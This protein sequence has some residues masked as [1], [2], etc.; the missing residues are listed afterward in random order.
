MKR[1]LVTFAVAFGSVS[2]AAC[3]TTSPTNTSP[4]ATGTVSGTFTLDA[5]ISLPRPIDGTV[6]LSRWH[7]TGSV[8]VAVGE[9]GKFT[10]HLPPGM[11]VVSGR[12][13]KFNVNNREPPCGSTKP[14]TVVANS[15]TSV[16]LQCVGK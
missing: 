11:W 14:I 3:G 6:S 15:T 7:G 13:P 12:S 1:M 2:L 5:G 10:V 16:Q 4:P 8:K 9:N